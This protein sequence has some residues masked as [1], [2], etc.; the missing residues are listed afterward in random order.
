MI[1]FDD[2]QGIR[3][4]I[5]R[6][7]VDFQYFTLFNILYYFMYSNCVNLTFLLLYIVVNNVNNY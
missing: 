5:R 7:N 6:C 4:L 1:D 2:L 3:Q